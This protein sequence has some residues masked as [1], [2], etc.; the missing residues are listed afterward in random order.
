[1]TISGQKPQN[2][3]PP[4]AGMYFGSRGSRV[5]I[6][7]LRPIKPGVSE[8]SAAPGFFLT[9]RV[10]DRVRAKKEAPALAPGLWALSQGS[11]SR[12]HLLRNHCQDDRQWLCS[13]TPLSGVLKQQQNALLLMLRNARRNTR[14]CIGIHRGH[15]LRVHPGFA[16]NR[17]SLSTLLG[18]SDILRAS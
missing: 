2:T 13:S 5:R 8:K 14:S 1:M 6:T 9:D 3:A 11:S 10:T 7:L 16:G 15:A 12:L 17:S 18:S 4:A